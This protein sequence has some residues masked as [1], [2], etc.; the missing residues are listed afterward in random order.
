[1]HGPFLPLYGSGAIMM[2]LVSTPFRGN[3]LLTYLA[4]CVGATILEYVTGVT[5]EALF[6]VRYWDYSYRKIQF[7]G[8]ICLVSSLTWGFLTILMTN[9]LHKP[10]EQMVLGIP[11][12][13]LSAVTYCLTAVIFADFAL[14]FKA[15]MDLR[16]ILIM[17]EKASMEVTQKLAEYKDSITETILDTKESITETI[18]DTK[19]SLAG[20]LH[21]TKESILEKKDAL[22]VVLQKHVQIS[23][24]LERRIGEMF[25]SYPGL[26]SKYFQDA[27]EVLKNRLSGPNKKN[28]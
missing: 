27:L 9:F 8:H 18:L 22:K 25:R 15:A 19:E 13:V 17:M 7:Q 23:K 10:I 3:L 12:Q 1:M 28:D 24:D 5:M 16:D 6:K 14:S 26:Q 4:G 20:A 2:L 21:D 11:L